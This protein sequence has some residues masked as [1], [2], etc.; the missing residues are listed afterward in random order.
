MLGI[1]TEINTLYFQWTTR[2]F[3]QYI[4]IYIYTVMHERADKEDFQGNRA[5]RTNR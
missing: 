1:A 3:P 5:E 4:H 2:S